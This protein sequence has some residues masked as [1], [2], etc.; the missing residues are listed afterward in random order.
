M[1]E[2]FEKLVMGVISCGQEECLNSDFARGFILFCFL[3]L[4]FFLITAD[5]PYNKKND[6]K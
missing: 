4:L 5:N 6:E 2:E 1:K 3:G